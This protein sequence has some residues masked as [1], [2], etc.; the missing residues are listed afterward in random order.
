MS[1]LLLAPSYLGQVATRCFMPRKL[2][3]GAGRWM[4]TRSVH[5]MRD[6]A[7]NPVIGLANWLVETSLESTPGPGLVRVSIEY[8]A[9]TFTE[10]D[11][12]IAAGS[13]PVAWP[14]GTSF[15][16]FRV[17]IPNGAKF[18]VRVLQQNDNGVLF[19]QPQHDSLEP[20]ADCAMEFGTGTPND[21]TM[22]GEI[23]ASAW[24]YHP[25]LIL[26]K[27]RRPSILAFGDSREEGGSEGPRPPYYDNGM[28]IGALARHFGYASMAESATYLTT[29][30]NGT[31]ENR[32]FRLALAPYF[33]HVLNAYGV[34][35]ISLGRTVEQLLADRAAFAATFAPRTVIGTTIMPYVPSS[36]GWRTKA[37]QT[38]GTNQ[39]KIR[40]ANR[41]IRAGISGEA[42]VLDTARVVDPF[43][44]DKYVVA[45]DPSATAG[46]GPCEFI[47]SISGTVLTVT[48][49]AS[50]TLAYGATLTD[51]LTGA[52]YTG[53][54][55]AATTVLEQLDG[56]VGG[57]GTYRVSFA[58]AVTSKTMYVG[59]WATN[60][61]LHG[62]AYIAERST[63][64]MSSQTSKITR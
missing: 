42:L 14:A 19:R 13:V 59:A 4:M 8:P 61:G 17:T 27:T 38:L 5:F 57:I 9:G 44:E 39:P 16:H 35:D 47:G 54:P 53:Q 43:D 51:T 40:T 1:E 25:V 60:D 56:A 46:A 23:A 31:A 18:W 11:E 3:A 12:N 30:V 29:F 26:A 28:C 10:S 34:N 41:A 22:G 36:D 15:F 49:I 33:S 63:A 50:G 37:G 62:S 52:P 2:L 64:Q 45:A 58:Q 55:Y 24:T 48:A 7:V 20:L 21:R 32:A 6:R